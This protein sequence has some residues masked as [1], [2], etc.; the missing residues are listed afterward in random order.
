VLRR[1]LACLALVVALLLLA[2]C[3]GAKHARLATFVGHWSGHT[4]GLDVYRSGRGREYVNAGPRAIMLRFVVLHAVGT[5]THSSARIR[6]TAARIDR[7][8]LSGGLRRHPPRVGQLG[9]LL[10]RRGVVTESLDGITYC[11]RTVDRCGL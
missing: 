8:A 7:K 2:G 1:L 5:P 9:T 3:G 11:A 6:I 4:R 10:L